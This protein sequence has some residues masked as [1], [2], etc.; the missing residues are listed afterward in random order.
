M[1]SR[2]LFATHYHELTEL[3]GKLSGV[4][5]YSILVEE[6]NGD[7]SFLRKIVRG[8]ADDS[9]GIHVAKLAGLPD[10]LIKRANEILDKLE[11]ADISKRSYNRI[12]IP[13]ESQVSIF[14]GQSEK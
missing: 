11:N 7:I 1:G 9:Y 5:N 2:A 6:N 12:K 3:E 14:G 4:K 13:I 10:E 8:G